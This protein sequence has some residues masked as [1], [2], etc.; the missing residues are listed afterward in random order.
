[1]RRALAIFTAVVVVAFG[2]AAVTA[3]VVIKE[4]LARSVEL[5][6]KVEFDVLPGESLRHVAAH[7]YES[8]LIGSER[9]FL[10]AAFWKGTDRAIKHG[11][12]E[13]TGTVTLESVLAELA[14]TPK[15]ILKVTIPEGL[16]LRDAGAVL[17]QAGAVSASAYL[18]V[19][20]SDEMKRLAGSPSSAGCAEGFLFPD[21]YDLVPG[22][23]AGDVV[24]LQWKRFHQVVDP[25]IAA[26]PSLPAELTAAAAGGDEAS[27]VAAVV[28]LA[29]IVE[30]ETAL[31]SERPHIAA[32]FYNRLRDGMPLQTDP[33]VI[34]GVID[35]GAPWDGN[36]TRAHL[37]TATP[38]NTY[39]RRGLPPGPICNPGKASIQAVLAPDKSRDLYFVARGDGSHE[40][41]MS[42]EDH[43]RAVRRWQ[44]R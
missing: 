10:G 41:N 28:T 44:L 37:T 4:E 29:S 8:G 19:A 2:A 40:F 16:T 18:A 43:N 1:M 14:R 6:G 30:K 25:L 13:F 5:A 31:A 33:T 35:S 23:S 22:M 32:V 36:L 12:H 20:C 11:R 24:D 39:M 42:L 3:T 15:P 9:V 27:R 17:E 7:L 26:S 38:Y 34:Y 21:T